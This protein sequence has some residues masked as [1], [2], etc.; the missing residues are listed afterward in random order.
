MDDVDH[1]SKR[2]KQWHGST[3]DE[4]YVVHVDEASSSSSSSSSSAAAAVAPPEELHPAAMRG[5]TVTVAS[6]L[7]NPL[8]D[9]NAADQYGDTALMKAVT[10][11]HNSV[12][13]VLLS[14]ERVNPNIE[15]HRDLRAIDLAAWNRDLPVLQLLLADGRTI[16]VRPEIRG[17]YFDAAVAWIGRQGTDAE[18]SPGEFIPAAREGDE[19]TVASALCNPLTDPNM[20]NEQ[21]CTALMLAA[22][23]G[24]ASVVNLLLGDVRVDPTLCENTVGANALMGA[25]FQEHVPVVELL[26]A[27]QRVDPNLTTPGAVTLLHFAATQEGNG[28]ILRLLLSDGRTAR[29]RPTTYPE[30][31]RYDAALR[32]VKQ[33][34]RARFKGLIRAV[35]VLSRRRLRIAQTL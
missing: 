30:C 3:S 32:A 24:H 17:E 9:P 31:E 33:P 14:D 11:Q 23:K 5:D 34:R 1:P 22:W 27:D 20:T 29:V 13:S 18:A 8:T 6:A 25:V 12:V 16:R 10:S 35:V 4:S 19:A 15:N 21:G 28:A 7:R 26:L 2:Y